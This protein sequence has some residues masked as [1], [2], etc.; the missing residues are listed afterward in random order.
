MQQTIKSAAEKFLKSIEGK[1][2]SIISHFDT[3]GITSAAIIAKTLNGLKKKFS[4]KIVKQIEPK[5]FEEIKGDVVLFID[6]GSSSLDR[7]AG[8]G[9]EAFVIDHHEIISEVPE[10]ITIVNPHLI[11]GEEISA[12]G[13]TYMF[14]RELNA[15]KELAN[16]AV[17]GMVGDMLDRELSKLNN[18]ILNDADVKVKKGLLLYPAT[19]PIN[20]SLEFGSGLYIPGVTG[21]PKGVFELLNE[22]GIKKENN[23]FK[24]LIDL[25]EEEMSRLLTA[26]LL[27]TKDAGSMIGNIYLIRFFNQL[28][29]AR[30]LSAMINACSRLGSSD[31]ALALCL[32]NKNA[33]EKAEDI[34]VRYKQE[35]IQG[36]NFAEQNKVEGKGYVVINARDSIKD[37]V[38]GTVMSMIS[39][40][41]A[42]QNGTVIVGMAYDHDN[43]KVSARICGREGRNVREVL[44]TATRE[45]PG[46]ECGGHPMAAGCL[47]K[48]GSEQIFMDNL[49]K[50]MELEVVKI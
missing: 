1:T 13:L 47:L 11:D 16:L 20:K 33:K 9:K 30:G 34:Y 42:Y 48:K 32:N 27:R 2:I 29:D 35:I 46:V 44:E 40:S 31:V 36:L 3:D 17:V 26:V 8:L 12:S 38:I 15:N 24:S 37:T 14:C 22:A 7:I 23:S 49:S 21:N 41:Q 6:L 5:I 4:I 25:N 28:E 19:R 50:A 18:E 10:N 45:L 39:T 43:V